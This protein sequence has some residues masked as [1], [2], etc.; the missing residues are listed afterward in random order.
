MEVVKNLSSLTRSISRQFSQTRLKVPVR[1]NSCIKKWIYNIIE[2]W[3]A[4][5]VTSHRVP[6]RLSVCLSFSLTVQFFVDFS[7]IEITAVSF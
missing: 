5:K 7:S 1:S 2:V 6:I 3:K 4:A